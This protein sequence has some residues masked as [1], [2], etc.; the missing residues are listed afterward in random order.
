MDEALKFIRR[1]AE[2]QRPFLAVVWFGNPHVPHEALPAD[3]QLY[4]DLPEDLQNYYGELNGIDRNVG[5]LR[6]ALKELKLAENTLLWYCSDNGGAAGPRS[7]GNLRGA[8]GTL[9]EGGLRVQDSSNG[10]P[11][12]ATPPSATSPAR[13][14]TSTPQ[15]SP[16]QV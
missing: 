4:A 15:C 12:S 5:K 7:T 14:W 11:A 3:K 10:P 13:L 1:Q 8:K 2:T 16:L 6:A 9:W